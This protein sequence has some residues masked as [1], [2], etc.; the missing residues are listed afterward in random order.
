MKKLRK[1]L[2]HCLGKKYR[3]IIFGVLVMILLLHIGI[4][5]GYKWEVH[6]YP[7]FCFQVEHL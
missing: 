5:S 7:E 3:K 4:P 2:K 6:V 1:E